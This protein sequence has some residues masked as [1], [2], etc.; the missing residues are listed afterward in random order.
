MR[1]LLVD[2]IREI[3]PGERIVGVKNA[4][5]SE[6][7]FTHHFPQR[8]IMPGLLVVESMVQLARWLVIAD[9][10]F[11]TSVLLD[12][13][14][15]CKFRGFAVPGDQIAIE[16]RRQSVDAD[17][18]RFAGA[19][20]V[21]GRSTVTAA[22]STRAVPLTDLEDPARVRHQFDVLQPASEGSRV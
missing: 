8:P 15:R 20:S 3:E 21:D 16:V 18:H 1:F 2:G 5:M 19:A 6:D 12:E 11:T 22:F 4:S 9:S 14:D 13:V 7:F 10:G 17:R